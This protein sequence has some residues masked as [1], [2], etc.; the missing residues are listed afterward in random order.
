MDEVDV[1]SERGLELV[2]L[3]QRGDRHAFEILYRREVGRVYALCLRMTCDRHRAETLTQDAFVRAWEVLGTFR[4]DSTFSTWMYRV[5]LN[6]VLAEM[7]ADRRRAARFE[8]EDDLERFHQPESMP[9][10]DLEKAIAV[11]P[12]QART[13]LIL[14]EIEGYTHE[15]IGETLEI[16]AGTSKAHLHRA[17]HLLREMLKS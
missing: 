14:H 8:V 16:S 1:T 2:R 15:E 10:M 3:A 11:L 7:R 9:M 5:G 6:V 12:P 4:G 17:R 13:V